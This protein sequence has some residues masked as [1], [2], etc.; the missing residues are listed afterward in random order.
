[1]TA[2]VSV[3]NRASIKASSVP[4]RGDMTGQVMMP[5]I[6]VVVGDTQLEAVNVTVPM[7]PKVAVV[8]VSVADIKEL[9]SV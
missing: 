9:R 3:T 5:A 1:M 6:D 8:A 7:S 2:Q 4:N